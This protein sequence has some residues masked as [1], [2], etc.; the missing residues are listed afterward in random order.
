MYNHSIL[1]MFVVLLAKCLKWLTNARTPYVLVHM[2]AAHTAFDYD[3]VTQGSGYTW[4]LC[5]VHFR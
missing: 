1:V 3:L 5:H 2:T 4:S